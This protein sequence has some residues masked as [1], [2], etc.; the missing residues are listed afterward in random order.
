MLLF[1]SEGHV[2]E[3]NR[4]AGMPTGAILTLQQMWDLANGWYRDRLSP[5]WRRRT[6]QNAQALL[7]DLGLAGS[8]WRLSP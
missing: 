3:W 5:D 6:P 1:R 2:N 7:Q 4:R 8:F